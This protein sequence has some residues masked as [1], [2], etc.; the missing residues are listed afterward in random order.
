MKDTN[1]GIIL[2]VLVVLFGL[3]YG[4][5]KKANQNKP[6]N[7]S[8]NSSYSSSAINQ[9]NGDISISGNKEVSKNIKE[10]EEDI[11][12]LEENI[13]RKIEESKRSPYYGKVRISNISGLYSDNPDQQYVYISTSLDKKE[14]V[15]ITGWYLKSEKT[16][17][18][19]VI[20]K[21]TLLP[22]PFTKADSNVILAYG[23][24]A[25][26][27][28]GFSPIGISFRTNKCTGFFEEN[29]TFTPSLSLSCPLPKDEKMPIFSNIAERNDE[30]LDVLEYIPRCSTR[31]SAFL[32]DLPDTVPSSCK[33]YIATQINYNTCLANHFDDTDF[34]G[35]EYRLYLNKFGP[36][37]RDRNEKINLHDR[38][39]LI[40]D[41]VSF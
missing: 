6:T 38:D 40:V 34:P 25:I 27:T 29:R 28:K 32:R 9:N 8:D 19:T 7:T 26:V 41:S 18:Y 4:P 10:I 23:D 35:D 22:F 39:G 13:N 16:G 33:D 31:D 20:P 21:A 2:L 3:A 30:C 17:Y 1:P 5:F 37:W 12:K 15:N 36:L 24:R 11:K 14:T